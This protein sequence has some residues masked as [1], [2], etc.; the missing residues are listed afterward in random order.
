MNLSRKWLTE[1]VDL[2]LAEIDDRSFAEA[3]T[4]SGSKVEVTEDLSRR[5]RSVLAGRVVSMERHPDSDHMFITEIDTGAAAPVQIVTGAWNVHTGDL[6]PVA[7]D[8]AVPVFRPLPRYPSVQRDIAVICDLPV[9]AGDLE[10]TI[11]SA[12]GERL[13]D[14]AVFDV[15]TGHHIVEGK[16]SVAF[17]LTMRDENQTLTDEHAEEI[18]RGVLTALKEKYGA[19]MR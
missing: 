5:I 7:L 1:F 12:G 17:R 10:A 3:M 19:E 8:G 16:K 4:V 6:V 11:R 15:Y 2:P 9:P 13:I 14:C 18:V